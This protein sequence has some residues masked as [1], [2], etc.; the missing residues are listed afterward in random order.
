MMR[1]VG[2]I[3][4][5]LYG[6]VSA[7]LKA[8]SAG[9]DIANLLT[10]MAIASAFGM[11]HALMPGHGKAVIVSYYLGR[12]GQILGGVMTSAVLA[13]THVGSA[14][15]LVL[16]GFIVI[17]STIGGVGR[18]PA[19]ETVS[20]AMIIATGLWLLI[21]S[22]RGHEHGPPVS[23][24]RALAVVTG[25]VPCPLTTFIMVYA[26]AQGIVLT[27]LVVTI[28]MALGMTATIASFA[29]AAVLLRERVVLLFERSEYVRKLLSHGLELASAL[30]IIMLGTWLLVAR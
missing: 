20:A 25:L 5:W 12:P 19:F 2:D 7:Q 11:I 1:L 28:G 18:A 6:G 3:Q 15:I 23:G 14:V 9:F 26:T 16:A 8:L 10:A 17:R 24:G 21:K 27:G 29:I 30:A 13:L 22:L 4:H